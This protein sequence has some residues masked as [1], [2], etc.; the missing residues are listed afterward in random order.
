MTTIF[1]TYN[2][3]IAQMRRSGSTLAEIGN[4]VGVTR[5]RIR[6]ILNQYYPGTQ[7]SCLKE[8]QLAKVIGCHPKR[9]IKL[10]QQGI[11][12]PRHTSGLYLY[13]KDEVEKAMLAIQKLCIHC[14]EPVPKYNQVYCAVCSAEQRRNPYKF[15]SEEG[16]KHCIEA[17]RNWQNAH[18]DRYKEICDRAMQKHLLKCR[19]EHFANTE[20]IVVQ[21]NTLPIDT[22]IKAVGFKNW[23]LILSNGSRISV[24]NIR[25]LGG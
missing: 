21:G 3:V 4:A 8:S 6:Q 10:R 1:E 19:Q 22:I 14:G 25:K 15:R 9:L 24:C 5:E 12:K 17:S 16:K 11:L 2:G 18:P 7:M 20:Y 23:H 13:D